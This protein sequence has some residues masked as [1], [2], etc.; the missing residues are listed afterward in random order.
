R[1]T[2]RAARTPGAASTPAS[3]IAGR[4]G[5]RH[6]DRAGAAASRENV[7]RIGPVRQD[8]ENA[9]DKLDIAALP[10]GS[11]PRTAGAQ[12]F[13]STL[14]PHQEQDVPGNQDTSACR[15]CDPMD[16]RLTRTEYTASLDCDRRSRSGARSSWPSPVVSEA[17][18]L[19]LTSS[20]N[21]W[22]WRHFF[23]IT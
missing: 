9:T 12:P 22:Q 21:H 23:L 15:R 16:N 14:R 13:R 20:T 17:S 19:F 5:D 2:L 6:G 7:C 18:A 11:T 1:K 3:A 4:A 8:S 10:F